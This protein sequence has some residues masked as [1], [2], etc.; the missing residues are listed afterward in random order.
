MR[1]SDYKICLDA[2]P[3]NMEFDYWQVK[4]SI[5]YQSM[6]SISGLANC[7]NEKLRILF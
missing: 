3:P 4:T 7:S 6:C 1:E 5:K 2:N